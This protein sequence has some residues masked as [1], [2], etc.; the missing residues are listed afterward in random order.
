MNLFYEKLAS[1]FF[2][3]I[4]AYFHHIFLINMLNQINSLNISY[5]AA[6]NR[7]HRHSGHLY[8]GRYQA[9]LIDADR[10]I[11]AVSR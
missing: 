5:T 6:Y 9:F 2:W 8:Q 7:R 1:D 3:N 4:F 11:V 10:Y